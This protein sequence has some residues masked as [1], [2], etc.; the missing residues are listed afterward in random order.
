M[1]PQKEEEEEDEEFSRESSDSSLNGRRK[2]VPID[3]AK[4]GVC[5]LSSQQ[6]KKKLL[7]NST[8][9]RDKPSVV[10]G[11]GRGKRHFQ[12]HLQRMNIFVNKNAIKVI[13]NVFRSRSKS[14]FC[15]AIFRNPPPSSSP[16]PRGG[17]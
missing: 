13:L 10:G 9:C 8:P 14:S 4:E 7:A 12:Q 5:E 3:K 17:R 15:C 6:K 11:S 1:V 16:Q 2:E